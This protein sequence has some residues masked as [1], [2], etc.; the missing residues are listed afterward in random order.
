MRTQNELEFYKALAD[1]L[2]T[3]LAKAQKTIAQLTPEKIC[4]ECG[5]MVCANADYCQWC[6]EQF[7]VGRLKFDYGCPDCRETISADAKFCD[8][9]GSGPLYHN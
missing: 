8:S 2:A 6:G 1:N 9:C 5:G 3:A 4:A 7:Y